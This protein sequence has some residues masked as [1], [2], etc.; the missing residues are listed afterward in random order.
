MTAEMFGKATGLGRGKGGHMHLFDPAHKFS[1]SGIIGASHA[2][3]LRRRA[4]R[5]EAGHR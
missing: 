1:C 3:C 5:E 4:G 2:A